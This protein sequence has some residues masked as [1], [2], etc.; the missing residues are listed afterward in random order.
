L[1][2]FCEC[3]TS[4]G[5]KMC[6]DDGCGGSC[7]ECDDDNACTED[8][9]D[10]EVGKCIHQEKDCNDGNPDTMD[11]CQPQSGQCLHQDCWIQSKCSHHGECCA[12]GYCDYG[13]EACKPIPGKSY[14]IPQDELPVEIPDEFLPS[15]KSVIKVTDSGIIAEANVKVMIAHPYISDLTV[16]LSNGTES[17]GL[18]LQSGGASD[19]LYSVYDLAEL[20]DGPVDMSVFHGVPVAGEWTLTVQDWLPGDKGILEDWRL[21]FVTEP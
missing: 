3:Q 8:S 5:A 18:H 12:D 16:S 17:V 9:C 6:G 19:N 10:A 20:P 14:L 21:Y 11:W 2:G 1:D 15:F 4:C 7:G 13:D